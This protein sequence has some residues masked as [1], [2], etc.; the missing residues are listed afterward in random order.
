[1]DKVLEE[2]RLQGASE[3]VHLRV[4]GLSHC[5]LLQ[6]LA[7]LLSKRISVLTLRTPDAIFVGNV[8]GHALRSKE[9]IAADLANNIAHGVRWHDA[10]SVLKELGCHLFLEM[11]SGHTLSDLAERNLPGVHAIPVALRALPKI[12]RL[13]QPEEANV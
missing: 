7:D 11:P 8:T 5:P 12:M 13:A 1:M 10:T 4:S 9:A 6:P 2:A 3:A